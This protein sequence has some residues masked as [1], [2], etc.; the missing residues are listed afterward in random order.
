[1]DA[2][3][4]IVALCVAGMT[5]EGEGRADEARRLFAHAWTTSV[6]DA[7][8]CVAAHYLARHQ[9]SPE[10][11]LHWNH[12]A[13]CRARMVN[14]DRVQGFYPSLYL[15]LG[16]SYED[17]GQLDEARRYYDLA[18]QRASGLP[19]DGYG[20]LVRRGISNGQRRT[21]PTRR[22]GNTGQP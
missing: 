22:D 7:E 16:R 9:E 13:L 2:T 4:P 1:M 17:L 10:Q 6:D 20:A 12:E 8:R 11:T 15:N 5:A 19:T 14:D 21:D 3:N 18:A